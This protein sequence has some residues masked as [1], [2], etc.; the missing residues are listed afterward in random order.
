MTTNA[1]SPTNCPQCGKAGR[2]Y[3]AREL[4]WRYVC[5]DH[6]TWAVAQTNTRSGPDNCQDCFEA[7]VN[8]DD[9]VSVALCDY[10]AKA[11]ER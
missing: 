8:R 3:V 9:D 4:Y 7:S 5:P 2:E 11:F 6:H 10:H 1:P